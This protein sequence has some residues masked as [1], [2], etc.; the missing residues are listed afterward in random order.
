[1]AFPAYW[2]FHHRWSNKKAGTKDFF[3]HAVSF[4]TVGGRTSAWVPAV[5]AKAENKNWHSSPHF[6]DGG[7]PL[8]KSVLKASL[9]R[10]EFEQKPNESSHTSAPTV[11]LRTK[12]TQRKRRKSNAAPAARKVIKSQAQRNEPLPPTAKLPRRNSRRAVRRGT[13]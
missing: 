5:Q 3:G 6:S 9:T 10:G 7:M 1:M 11:E 12:S 4:T 13:R 2:L 8:Y